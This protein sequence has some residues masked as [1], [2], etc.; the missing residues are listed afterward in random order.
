MMKNQINRLLLL[1]ILII[2]LVQSGYSQTVISPITYSRFIN[3]VDSGNLDFAAQKLNV[4]I[5]EAQVIAAKVRNDPQLGINYFNNEQPSKQM[6]YGGSVSISQTVT[7]GKRSA[8]IK[9]AKS[10][11]QLSQSLLADYLRNLHAD[12]AISFYSALKQKM[13]YQVKQHAYQSILSL[14]KSDSIRYAK[15]EI[16]EIDAIQSKVEAGVEYTDLL[17][18]ATD[19]DKA[20]SDLSLY[21]GTKKVSLIYQ[22]DADLRLPYNSF[23][24]SDLIQRGITERA[25][26]VAA[27]QNVD[28]A[29]KALVVAKREKNIDLTVSLEVQHSAEVKNEIAPA[30]SYNS[31]NAGLSIPI[32][33]SKLNK[34]NIMAAQRRVEQASL[35][36]DQAVLQVQND[37]L[38]SYTQYESAAKQV[39]HFED[40]LLKQ[41]KD[42]L[43][44][45][46]Y[47]YKRGDISLLEVLNA[48]RTY[49]DVQSKYIETLFDYDSA[50]VELQRSVGSENL[51]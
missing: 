8:A 26:L 34:G 21:T 18:A 41:A 24:L 36:Y 30:P 12:A 23:N 38:K 49:D 40:G 46:I 51:K 31:Y 14:A 50:L 32:P 5:A 25:D 13:L 2:A 37:I 44:G 17:Q 22:P 11:N 4:S 42:V 43:D 10:E 39:R 6:G 15:G 3:K 1:V 20:Y 29:G 19:R 48:R 16:M 35:Q 9:L 27:M 7:F 45:K 33:F 47:S 28:V